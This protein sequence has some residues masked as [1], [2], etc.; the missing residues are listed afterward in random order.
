MELKEYL[1]IFKKYSLF[2]LILAAVGSIISYTYTIKLSEGT[3]ASQLFYVVTPLSPTTLYDFE[4]FYAQEKARNFTDT[5][6]IIL[7]SP[8]FNQEIISSPDTISARK[9]A[10]QLIRLT[11]ESSSFASAQA[12][13]GKTA[14]SFNQK[15]IS[16]AGQDQAIQ[17][18]AIGQ[19]PIISAPSPK[20]GIIVLFGAVTGMIFA[21]FIAGIKTYFKL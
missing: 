21:I 16:L 9:L 6:V 8:D 18:K 12:L 11:V 20:R 1:L 17:I 10:P 14:T 3:H 4:G 7:E 19:G 2:I 13:I 5:A 15:L